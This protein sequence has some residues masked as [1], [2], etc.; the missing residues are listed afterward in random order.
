MQPPQPARM[1]IPR[2]PHQRGAARLK[3]K[4]SKFSSSCSN[5]ASHA[6]LR[7][8]SYARRFARG[9]KRESGEMAGGSREGNSLGEEGVEEGERESSSSGARSRDHLLYSADP[10]RQVRAGDCGEEAEGAR[11]GQGISAGGNTTGRV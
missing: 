5:P 9:K 10:P 7:P 4:E 6:I 8:K 11:R 3:P 1:C 2:A